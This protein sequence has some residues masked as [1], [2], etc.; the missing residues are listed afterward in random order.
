MGRYLV[1]GGSGFIGTHLVAKLLARGDVVSNIDI[2]A[3]N[4]DEHRAVWTELDLLDAPAVAGHVRDFRP[5]AVINLAA[6]ADIGLGREA[7]R[8]NTAGVDNLL[9]ACAGLSPRPRL[10][11]TS[12]QMVAMPGYQIKGPR[13]Y[14]PYTEYGE[15]KAESEEILHEHKGDVPWTI[16]RPTMIWGPWHRI[17]ADSTFRYLKR[18]W[19]LIVSGKD[20]TRNY[21]YV[22]NVAA[23]MIAA[24]DCN[25]NECNR[26]T[27]YV[28]DAPMPT[29]RWID[30][31]SRALTGKP[32]RRVPY[33]LLSALAW[34]G[35]ISGK[36]GGPSPVN[37][38]RLYRMTSEY[39][40]DMEPT[41]EIFGPAP[42]SLEQGIAETVAWLKAWDGAEF[43][44]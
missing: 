9:A 10:V 1:T 31:F 12:T 26:R 22:G 7:M 21:G 27:F 28:G 34:V 39:I 44:K 6:I 42:V 14:R 13:D 29:S 24:A 16:L 25:L 33:A 20:P 41:F 19:Y 38:G 23:Q 15:T 43:A 32:A 2:A 18:R 3:P 30:G 36:I 11:H 17:L 40:A 37:R 8:V 5:D 35:E 4:L